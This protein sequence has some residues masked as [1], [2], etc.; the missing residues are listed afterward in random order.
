MLGIYDSENSWH[1]ALVFVLVVRALEIGIRKAASR[2]IRK[3][4]TLE[5]TSNDASCFTRCRIARH[6]HKTRT[7]TERSFPHAMVSYERL[8]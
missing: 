7:S 3:V 2:G 1:T 6:N 4:T 5:R 8:S